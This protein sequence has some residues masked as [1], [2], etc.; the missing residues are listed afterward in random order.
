MI[1]LYIFLHSD[2]ESNAKVGITNNLTGIQWLGIYAITWNF[3]PTIHFFCCPFFGIILYKSIDIDFSFLGL[4]SGSPS[5]NLV[6]ANDILTTHQFILWLPPILSTPLFHSVYIF[7]MSWLK[8][9]GKGRGIEMFH[10]TD[11]VVT[12]LHFIL[13]RFLERNSSG[14]WEGVV[15][16]GDHYSLDKYYRERV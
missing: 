16:G 6:H 7:N 4:F 15:Y 2:S 3:K 5:S 13:W 8:W 14:I 12:V 1:R 9:C 11:N 10:G